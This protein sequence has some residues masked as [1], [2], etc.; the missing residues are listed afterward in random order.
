MSAKPKAV[1]A[2]GFV[3]ASRDAA[4]AS[5]GGLASAFELDLNPP[6]PGGGVERI[7]TEI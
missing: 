7:A 3:A 2:A 6:M 5:L 4:S 1:S